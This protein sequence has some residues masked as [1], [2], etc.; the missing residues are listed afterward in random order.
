MKT[1]F[2]AGLLAVSCVAVAQTEISEYK[3]GVTAEGVVYF[4]P[5]TALRIAVQVEKSTY[6]P[7]DFCKYAERYLR[8]NDVEQEAT[9]TYKVTNIGLT[10]FGVADEKKAYAVKFNPKSVAANVKLSDDGTLLAIN[11]DAKSPKEPVE[12]T[13]APK[14]VPENPRKYMDEDILASGSVAKMAEMTAQEI[15]EIRD[16]KNQLNRGEADF[17]P[18]DGEQLK[19]MLGNL[20]KQ[21]R[22]LTQMFTGSTVKDTTEYVFVV[23][24][25]GEVNKQIVFRLSQKLGLVDKDDLSGTPYYLSIEDLHSLP[26][27]P[28]V[29]V[30][31]NKK[32]KASTTETGIYVNIPGKIRATISKGNKCIGSF[33]LYAGQYGK[34]ELLSGDLFNKRSTTHLS[35][36]PVTGSVD[37]LEAEMPK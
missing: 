20:D 31:E 10:S 3:P 26:V 6:T 14:I 25:D 27:T 34:V 12:F 9:V 30:D 23:V 36:N 16:S 33:E 37:K 22:M 18:K 4:L 19:I 24:P 11:T 13:P 17:M 28:S 29:V 35:I 8:M 15:Y 2:V 32:K 21:E 7:G 5:K 1:F